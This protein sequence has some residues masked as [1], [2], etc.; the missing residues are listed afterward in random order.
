MSGK[1][2]V[3]TQRAVLMAGVARP[4]EAFGQVGELCD[5]RH[6]VETTHAH[7][8][9]VDGPA[10]EHVEDVVADL[11]EPEAPLD[12]VAM[13][14]RKLDG[15]LVTEKVR[16]VE[17]IDVQRMAFDPLAAV[18]E[19]AQRTHLRVDRHAARI[20]D[21]LAGAHLV[22]DRADSANARGDVGDLGVRPPR[23]NASKNRGGSKMRNST[24]LTTPSRTTTCML[25]SPST[26]ASEATES[27]R[28]PLWVWVIGSLHASWAAVLAARNAG[29][30]ALKVRK[31]TDQV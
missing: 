12:D 22:R 2:K 17:K 31:H 18:Q 27:V 15:A 7:V 28:D 5:R 13:V 25:P 30:S 14:L 24:S 16:R 10:A 4:E 6:F 9:R 23:R 29:A 3:A 8:D 21:R 19:T 26:R 20:L 11:L 1:S